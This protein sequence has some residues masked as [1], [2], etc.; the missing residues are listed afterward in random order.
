MILKI[1]QSLPSLPASIVSSRP[2]LVG[3]MLPVLFK[4]GVGLSMD[5]GLKTLLKG[6]PLCFLPVGLS[7]LFLFV[8]VFCI[9]G[10][11]S[12]M[13]DGG[14]EGLRPAH[15]FAFLLSLN[16]SFLLG[17]LV[18]L[19]LSTSLPGGGKQVTCFFTL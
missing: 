9:W 10:K 3:V 16:M 11:A 8:V 2:V 1:G 6:S 5:V 18:F 19:H 12:R 15:L 13:W 7:H 4:W 14:E 17:L